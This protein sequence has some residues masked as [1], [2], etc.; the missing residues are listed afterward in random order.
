MMLVLLKR[1]HPRCLASCSRLG[2]IYSKPAGFLRSVRCPNQNSRSININSIINSVVVQQVRRIKRK[3]KKCAAAYYTHPHS[4]CCALIP[5]AINSSVLRILCAPLD[6]STVVAF[7]EGTTP[8]IN[9]TK[10]D[11]IPPTLKSMHF[12]ADIALPARPLSQR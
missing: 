2:A 11:E 6:T 1:I 9:V 10:V 4:R 3:R 8:K 7:G 5:H 12:V